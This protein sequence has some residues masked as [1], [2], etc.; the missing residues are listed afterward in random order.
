MSAPKPVES[1]ASNPLGIATLAAD[2]RA[3]FDS[4]GT[5]DTEWGKGYVSGQIDAFSTVLRLVL[6]TTDEAL[7]REKLADL[8]LWRQP[9]PVA[10][11]PSSSTAS[12]SEAFEGRR[13]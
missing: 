2:Y 5:A 9:V 12:S 8:G 3:H 10:D 11:A 4:L 6:G 7:V 1:Y 13:S